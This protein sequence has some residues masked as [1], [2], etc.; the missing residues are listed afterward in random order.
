VS[1]SRKDVGCISRLTCSCAVVD[2]IAV[3]WIDDYTHIWDRLVV[4]FAKVERSSDSLE[5]DLNVVNKC[6]IL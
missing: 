3:G 1:K 2:V 6:G 4:V 5:T